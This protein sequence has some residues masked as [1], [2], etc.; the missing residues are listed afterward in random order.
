MY[1]L[2]QLRHF[3]AKSRP[4]PLVLGFAGEVF[5]NCFLTCFH[6]QLCVAVGFGFFP[7]VTSSFCVSRGFS[8]GAPQNYGI[9]IFGSTGAFFPVGRTHSP[10]VHLTDALSCK[11]NLNC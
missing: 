2:A 11:K 3:L 8:G 7:S 4:L 6:L 10:S 1:F 5:F 9:K